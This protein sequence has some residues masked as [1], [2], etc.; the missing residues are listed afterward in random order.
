MF[1]SRLVEWKQFYRT[2]SNVISVNRW[3]DF[4]MLVFVILLTQ[5]LVVLLL[6]SVYSILLFFVS[7]NFGPFTLFDL[8]FFCWEGIVSLSAHCKYQIPQI[9]N[10]FII[11]TVFLKFAVNTTTQRCTFSNV[12]ALTHLLQTLSNFII[13][14]T[15]LCR[16]KLQ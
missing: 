1:R 10:F 11:S 6:S 16:T 7:H 14:Y 4:R 9:L 2:L 15:P 12:M 3:F 5:L 8:V 13:R